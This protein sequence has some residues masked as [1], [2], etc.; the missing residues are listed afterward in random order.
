MKSDSALFQP[1]SASA[2]ITLR[3][4][5][6]ADEYRRGLKERLRELCAV[7]GNQS[8]LA[9]KI[10]VPSQHICDIVKG[11]RPMS[12]AMVERLGRLKA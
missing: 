2:N 8:H 6:L 7:R 3:Y 5:K 4:V 12:D 11:R 9:R 1:V 10:G